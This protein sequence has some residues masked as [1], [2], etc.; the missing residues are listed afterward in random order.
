MWVLPE[1]NL[2][3]AIERVSEVCLSG[4]AMVQSRIDRVAD[5]DS[6]GLNLAPPI[7]HVPYEFEY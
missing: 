5:T 7:G 4:F 1:K 2:R 6:R 3:A